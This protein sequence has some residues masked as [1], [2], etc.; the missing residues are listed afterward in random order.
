MVKNLD[1]CASGCMNEYFLL[2]I[3]YLHLQ[4]DVKL[5]IPDLGS[6]SGLA[7]FVFVTAKVRLPTSNSGLMEIDKAFH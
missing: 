2:K 6:S 7:I 4:P 1:E 5:W 3:S